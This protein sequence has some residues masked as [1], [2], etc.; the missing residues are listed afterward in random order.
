[1]SIELYSPK[2]RQVFQ[3]ETKNTGHIITEGYVSHDVEKLY[4]RI[5]EKDMYGNPINMDWLDFDINPD[6]SFCENIDMYAGGWYK[7]EFKTD[8]GD[9]IS[10]DHIG[11]GE[12]IVGA[13][14][15]N[16][17]NSGAERIATISGMVSCTDGKIWKKAEDPMLGTHD[18]V[19]GALYCD[20]GSFYPALGDALFEEFHVP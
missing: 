2:D 5:S 3:R 17:T 8:K 4:I 16:S 18:M 11:I 12:V 10:V 7:A 15:S 13:G 1:M 9:Y 6:R 19:S 20:G 14:Q